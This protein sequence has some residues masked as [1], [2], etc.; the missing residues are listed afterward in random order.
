[1]YRSCLW[2]G[3]VKFSFDH[4]LK[5]LVESIGVK[6]LTIYVPVL[7]RGLLRLDCVP[8]TGTELVHSNSHPVAP[9]S[10]PET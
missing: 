5:F 2:E 3:G 8:S 10:L 7:C 9:I 1:M 4:I 6:L